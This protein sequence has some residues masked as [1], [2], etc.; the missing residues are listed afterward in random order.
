MAKK[1][2]SAV[3][4]AK[5]ELQNARI[6]NL[7]SAPSSPAVG[8]VYFDTT[9]NKFGTWNGSTW[10][11]MGTSTATGDVSGPI[12][13]TD[14]EVAIYSGTTGK[15]I[16]RSNTISGIA[17]LTS[18][19][20]GTA[21]SGTDFAPATS[22]NQILKGNNSGGF[23]AAV[24]GTDFA[25][26]TS[27][28]GILKGNGSGGFSTASA[29]TDYYNPGGTDVALADGGTGASDAAGA[30][31]NLGLVIGTNV[32]APNGN[33]SALTGITQSQ[34]A[35]LT[36]DLAAK[37][38]LASPT[39][40]GTV[41]V[42]TPTNGTDAANKNY[43]DNAVQGLSWKQA[44]RVAT[45]STVNL[46]AATNTVDG[47]TLAQGDRVLVKSQG[48]A[49][50]NGIYVVTTVGTGANGVWNRSSDADTSAEIDS[51]TVYVE[52]GTVNADTV[53]TLTTDN[54]TIGSTSLAYA[55]IN[56]GAVPTA[57][58]TTEGKVELATNA[59][60]I[61]HTDTTR[62]VTPS[63]LA[64]YTQTYTTTIGNGSATSIAVTHSLGNQWV[65]AQVIEVSTLAEV[66]CDIIRTSATQTTFEF[67]VA[68][69]TNQYR[70]IIAG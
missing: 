51:M 14:G 50:Q 19:V 15:L 69:T 63:G 57:S 32:L 52:Q 24:S 46:A 21:V 59:E 27:G 20:L 8:Q 31:T 35:N 13:S 34:I 26:S 3:D 1:F 62:A 22:G 23:A 43:V 67:S 45:T 12:A 65:I 11:Y 54:P 10:D 9:L 66:M 61:A 16:K 40:T 56:G 42:P 33:G 30:R 7:A 36:T 44:V 49:S 28:S 58:T 25:P 53:W 5:N 41:T 70:V 47:I 48:T 38:P 6:Q 68:P 29:G 37:A 18:G 2:L 17:K 55:Q 64:T 4:L 39:F 60:A